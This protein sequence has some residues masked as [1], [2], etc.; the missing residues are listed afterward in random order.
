MVYA[1]PTMEAVC[2][3]EV[4]KDKAVLMIIAHSPTEVVAFVEGNEYAVV[5]TRV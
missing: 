4:K 3:K 5:S 2:E 1:F